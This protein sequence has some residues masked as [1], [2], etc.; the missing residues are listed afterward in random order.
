MGAYTIN[1]DM[2]AKC[3]QCGKKGA[4]NGGICLNCVMKNLRAGKY[5][6][7]L[8]PLRDELEREISK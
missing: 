2:D 8:K 6:S 7:R 4:I 3:K 5:E 1:I